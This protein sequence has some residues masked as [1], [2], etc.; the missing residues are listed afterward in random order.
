MKT[1]TDIFAYAIAISGAFSVLVLWLYSLQFVFRYEIRYD[2][3]HY[4]LFDLFTVGRIS[5]DRIEDIQLVQLWPVPHGPNLQQD[6]GVLF[7]A[8]W[9]SK[10]FVRQGVF[11]RTRKGTFRVYILSPDNPVEFV[12]QVRERLRSFNA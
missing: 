12:N 5:I 11:I 9:P 3:I 1:M 2:A 4:K 8:K 10:V 7:S 6:I